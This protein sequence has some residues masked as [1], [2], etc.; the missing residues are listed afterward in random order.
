MTDY[1]LN[2]KVKK[3]KRM[4]ANTKRQYDRAVKNIHSKNPV[5]FLHSLKHKNDGFNIGYTNIIIS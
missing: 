4:S 3:Q 2:T 1:T 5:N